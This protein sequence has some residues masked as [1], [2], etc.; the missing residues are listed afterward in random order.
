MD[1]CHLQLSTEEDGLNEKSFAEDVWKTA[2]RDLSDASLIEAIDDLVLLNPPPQGQFNKGHVNECIQKAISI[3]IARKKAKKEDKETNKDVTPGFRFPPAWFIE[4]DDLA[5]VIEPWVEHVRNEIFGATSP[6]FSDYQDAVEWLN[7]E[8]EK[9]PEVPKEDVEEAMRL[10]SE[11]KTKL[12]QVRQLLHHPVHPF[13]V[14]QSVVPYADLREPDVQ[15]V[16]APIDTPLGLLAEQSKA[17]AEA[18]GL[19]QVSVVAYILAN[20]DPVIR[21]IVVQDC[22]RM[23]TMPDGAVVW[24]HHAEIEVNSGNISQDDFKLVFKQV[25]ESIQTGGRKKR[26]TRKHRTL[27]SVLGELGEQPTEETVKAYWT[28]VMIAYNERVKPEDR[29]THWDGPRKAYRRYLQERGLA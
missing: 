3:D 6:P 13:R 21:P 1:K 22:Q 7:N 12:W 19:S 27:L 10:M 16:L 25:K 14:E 17:I 4:G 20:I 26:L 23:S 5:N 18:T 15:Y 11:A 29:Y 24:R 8:E 9:V 28:R 2:P